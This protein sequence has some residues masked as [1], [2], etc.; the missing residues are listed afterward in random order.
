MQCA[1]FIA[2]FIFNQPHDCYRCVGKDPDQPFSKFQLCFTEWRCRTVPS[3]FGVDS[4]SHLRLS[5]R[6][7]ESNLFSSHLTSNTEDEQSQRV[8]KKYRP[9]SIN[10]QQSTKSY[11][12]ERDNVFGRN[13]Y[14]A[15]GLDHSKFIK[16][17]AGSSIGCTPEEEEV[18][19]IDA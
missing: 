6:P 8:I 9:L 5:G 10:L 2:L 4:E 13:S 3:K 14:K 16:D 15:M 1:P 12:L 7:M 17:V 11:D 18:F 19:G